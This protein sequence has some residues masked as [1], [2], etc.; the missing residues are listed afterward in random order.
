MCAVFG[1]PV[2]AGGGGARGAASPAHH[3]RAGT[4]PLENVLVSDHM[5]TGGRNITVTP[6]SHTHTHTHTHAQTT[7]SDWTSQLSADAR[8]S[9]L[10]AAELGC[11]LAEA[12]LVC[13]AATYLWNYSHQWIEQDRPSELVGTFRP[14]LASIKQARLQK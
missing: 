8:S 9:F 2:A 6:H 10:R 5:S 14:L 7:H 3:H 1:V 12:W 11:S 13:N 4:R